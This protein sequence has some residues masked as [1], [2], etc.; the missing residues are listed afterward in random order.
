MLTLLRK[1]ARIAGIDAAE[2]PAR[3]LE[4]RI[5]RELHFLFDSRNAA[6]AGVSRDPYV[7]VTVAA[8]GLLLEI[9]QGRGEI[10]ARVATREQPDDWCDLDLALGIAETPGLPHRKMFHD[11]RSV[12]QA[13]E[14]GWPKLAGVM[15]TN[16][17]TLRMAIEEFNQQ[18][19]GPYGSRVP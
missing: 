14:S 8:D 16:P 19:P 2:D 18:H 13:I 6:I 15:R 7:C 5:R 12:A 10:A 11:F 17:A 1:L 9:S 4:Q 3:A